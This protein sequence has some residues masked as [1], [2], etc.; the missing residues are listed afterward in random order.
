MKWPGSI[1]NLCIAADCTSL[2]RA[3]LRNKAHRLF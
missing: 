1:V 3:W 2:L